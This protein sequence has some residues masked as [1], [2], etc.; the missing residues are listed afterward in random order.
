MI[1]FVF[2]SLGLT[3]TGILV[4]E[5]ETKIGLFFWPKI[6]K[7]DFKKKKL[8]LVVVEDEQEH[9]FVFRYDYI[10]FDPQQ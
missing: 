8:T 9:T 5:G 2:F 1:S 10:L 3:P 6:T 7:L 4:F